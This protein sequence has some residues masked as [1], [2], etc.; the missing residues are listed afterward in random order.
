MKISKVAQLTNVPIS[1]IRY[2][3]DEGI[4]CKIPRTSGGRREFSDVDV[5]WLKN[6][7]VLRNV[8]VSIETLRR[9]AKLNYAAP[10]ILARRQDLLTLELAKIQGKLAELVTAER[11]LKS[12]IDTPTLLH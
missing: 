12:E 4:L 6:I 3:D 11:V 1:T 8:G 5:T 2:Y 10:D 7:T 9:L